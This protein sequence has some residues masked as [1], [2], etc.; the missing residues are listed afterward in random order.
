MECFKTGILFR[1]ISFG[2]DQ[3]HQFEIVQI[4]ASRVHGEAME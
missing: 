3:Q 4:A 2:G 1:D